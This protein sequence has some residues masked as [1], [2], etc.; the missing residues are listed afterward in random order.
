[1]LPGRQSADKA[2]N[3]KNCPDKMMDWFPKQQTE[4]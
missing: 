1:M 2:H 4:K 3:R